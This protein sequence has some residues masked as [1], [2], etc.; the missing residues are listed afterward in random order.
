VTLRLLFK[1]KCLK[2][3]ALLELEIKTTA[4][5]TVYRKTMAD[6]KLGWVCYVHFS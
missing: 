4:L 2:L 1:I 3:K 5:V 6:K